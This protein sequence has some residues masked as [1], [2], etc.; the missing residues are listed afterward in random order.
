[1]IHKDE[2]YGGA[3]DVFYQKRIE[4]KRLRNHYFRY[5]DSIEKYFRYP[6]RTEEHFLI[7]GEGFTERDILVWGREAGEEP[8]NCIGVESL[9][10]GVGTFAAFGPPMDLIRDVER[11]LVSRGT[12]P[13][14]ITGGSLT[15]AHSSP[16]PATTVFGL[17][18][19]G[20]IGSSTYLDEL[21]NRLGEKGFRTVYANLN[22][23]D[24][25]GLNP[26]RTDAVEISILN[27]LLETGDQGIIEGFT[28]LFQNVGGG[29]YLAFTA[30]A[31]LL[32][33]TQV[34]KSGWLYCLE[35]IKESG[36]IDFIILDGHPHLIENEWFEEHGPG[37]L[38][39]LDAPE[40]IDDGLSERL[41][42]DRNELSGWEFLSVSLDRSS[43]MKSETKSE[44]KP[45]RRRGEERKSRNAGMEELIEHLT[46]HWVQEH[47]HG[48]N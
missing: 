5:F 32:H 44:L 17:G 7:L 16:G 33:L 11:E 22:P 21:G 20:G 39:I 15:N 34:R 1:M 27:V 46:A 26:S 4:E 45:T 47:A 9:R 42:K 29:R 37:C 6:E 31:D 14:A 48:R 43:E 3:L 19:R 41:I 30:A 35:K 13:D 18:V 25:R 23:Y 40:G 28:N 2:D 36:G 38:L 12:I 10:T 24:L 8:P